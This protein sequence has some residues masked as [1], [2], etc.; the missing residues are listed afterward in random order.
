[1]LLENI[2][3]LTAHLGPAPE[4]LKQGQMS[5]DPIPLDP[6]WREVQDDA[7]VPQD[8][9]HICQSQV[10]VSDALV[11]HKM[12]QSLMCEQFYWV[13]RSYVNMTMDTFN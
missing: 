9:R 8:P 6:S 4:A 1:M 12:Y 13:P 11:H 3:S 5:D 7:D 2:C 10:G